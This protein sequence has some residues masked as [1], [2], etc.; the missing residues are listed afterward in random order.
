MKERKLKTFRTSS[1]GYPK[2]YNCLTYTYVQTHKY[3]GRAF[4]DPRGILCA[5]FEEV[6]KVMLRA[7]GL[8]DL[9]INKSLSL[10]HL[11]ACRCYNVIQVKYSNPNQRANN[12]SKILW[13]YKLLPSL[14]LIDIYL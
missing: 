3:W 12:S 1:L 6:H 9:T 13:S 8:L 10:H 7:L 11:H 14:V 4:H 2:S 5:K